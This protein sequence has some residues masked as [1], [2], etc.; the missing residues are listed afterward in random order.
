LDAAD[1]QAAELVVLGSRGRSGT[2]P[3][4]LGGVSN[5]VVHNSKRPVLIVPPLR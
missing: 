1:E 4:V 5:G 3:M 2:K